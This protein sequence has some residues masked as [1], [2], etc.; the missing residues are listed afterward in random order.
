MDE[1][2]RDMKFFDGDGPI[3]RIGYILVANDVAIDVYSDEERGARFTCSIAETVLRGIWEL[4]ADYGFSNVDVEV[5]LGSQAEE[6]QIGG[7]VVQRT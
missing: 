7:I 3:P 1:I 5:F 4:L 2:V 6:N